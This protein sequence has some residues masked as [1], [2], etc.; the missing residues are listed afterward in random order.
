VDVVVSEFSLV[1]GTFCPFKF[2]LAFFYTF[3]C[4]GRNKIALIQE[5]L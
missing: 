1:D 4:D 2:A 3:Y 5:K